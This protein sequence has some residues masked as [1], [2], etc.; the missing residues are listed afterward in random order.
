MDKDE[1]KKGLLK[2]ELA[3]K[4]PIQNNTSSI[5]SFPT[6]KNLGESEV[7]NNSN[8]TLK[9]F[10]VSTVPCI[11][12]AGIEFPANTK[13][14]RRFW[15]SYKENSKE[16]CAKTADVLVR[17]SKKMP[18]KINMSVLITSVDTYC[19]NAYQNSGSDATVQWEIDTVSFKKT[20]NPFLVEK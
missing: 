17:A 15:L 10:R 9:S 8:V 20:T 3:K 12:N 19:L 4:R 14:N 6:T 7:A 13:G 1:L 16:A 5:I 11:V 2:E 18:T